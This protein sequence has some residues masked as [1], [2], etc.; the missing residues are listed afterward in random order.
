MDPAGLADRCLAHR[1]VVARETAA[2][3]QLPIVICHRKETDREC[4]GRPKVHLSTASETHHPIAPTVSFPP[5]HRALLPS[6]FPNGG[7]HSPHERSAPYPPTPVLGAGNRQRSR[8]WRIRT[9]KSFT[10]RRRN[11]RGRAAQLTPSESSRGTV[12]GDQSG[13]WTPASHGRSH[14]APKRRLR[15]AGAKRAGGRGHRSPSDASGD[16]TLAPEKCHGRPLHRK[17]TA[18]SARAVEQNDFRVAATERYEIIL[19][20]DMQSSILS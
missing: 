9:S 1:V 8:A 6:R 2:P 17:V 10:P 14:G 13:R 11:V 4:S 3:Q 19:P 20:P 12:T 18:R 16:G 15:P 7:V 5:P